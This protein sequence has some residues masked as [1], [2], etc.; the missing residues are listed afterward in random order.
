MIAANRRLHDWDYT[1]GTC[2]GCA[3]TIDDF[4]KVGG[5]ECAMSSVAAQGRT[6]DFGFFSSICLT[7]GAAQA[8]IVDGLRSA[9]C[10]GQKP[11]VSAAEDFAVIRSRMATIEREESAERQRVP[12]EMMAMLPFPTMDEA[13][14]AFVEDQERFHAMLVES[15]CFSALRGLFDGKAVR[16][17]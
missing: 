12:E 11:R 14:K 2:T 17:Q 6:H 7:C 15:M 3:R 4:L 13:F 5:V 9:V 10:S 8:E 1:K 16:K